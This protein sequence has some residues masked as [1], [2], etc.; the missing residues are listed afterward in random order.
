MSKT[1]AR[2]FSSCAG[3]SRHTF[4]N[5]AKFSQQQQFLASLITRTRRMLSSPHILRYRNW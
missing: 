3:S 5:I 4:E 2:E 1:K